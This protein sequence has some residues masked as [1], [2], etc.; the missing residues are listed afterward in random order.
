MGKA[1]SG[2]CGALRQFV[3][4]CRFR[5]SEMNDPEIR[6]SK[7][8]KNKRTQITLY[9]KRIKKEQAEFSACSDF[10]L[11]QEDDSG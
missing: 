3:S 11:W 1:G 2:F 4:A 9:L 8:I 10:Q 6:S 7:T 5:S